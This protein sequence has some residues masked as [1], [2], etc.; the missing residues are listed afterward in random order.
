MAL[1]VCG[2]WVRLGPAF[3]GGI[4][5]YRIPGEGIWV[6]SLGFGDVGFTAQGRVQKS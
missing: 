2:V 1:R 3:K 5:T 4:R 6:Q